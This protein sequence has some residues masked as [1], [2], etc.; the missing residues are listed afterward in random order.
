MNFLKP[1]L[2]IILI[3][4]LIFSDFAIAQ[5]ETIQDRLGITY[6]LDKLDFITYFTK[7]LKQK[8]R[9]NK[10][11][12]DLFGGVLQGFDNNIFLD[13]S[14]TRDGFLQNSV[15]GELT[16]H[17]TDDVRL[18]LDTDVTNITYYRF[19]DNNL[20]DIE[21]N[22]GIELDF[23]DDYLTFEAD[24]KFEWLFFPYDEDGSYISH[25]YSSFLQNNICEEFYHR[26]GF[27]LEYKHFTDRKANGPSNIKKSDLREDIRH[28]GEYELGIYLWDFIKIKENIQIYRNDSNNQY[29]DYY[30]YYAFRTKTSIVAVFTEKLYS[31]TSFAYTRKLYDD[32]LSTEDNTHQKD[33]FYVFN[34]SLLYELTPSFTLA[35]GYSYR[36]NTSNEPL[37]KYSGSIC[38]VGLYYTF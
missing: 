34:V 21:G 17:C 33:N 10:I 7:P 3:A 6:V 19:N 16:Y 26:C 22:P 15:A 30:D 8:L 1:L 29:Y 24:Y 25:Q 4:V 9:E 11:E 2:F 37:E 38:T 12:L 18:N 5:D 31:I 23:L 20:L 36:E 35:T 27:R 13:P 32:R 28:T 14:R